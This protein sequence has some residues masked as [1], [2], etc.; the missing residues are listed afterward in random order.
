M[1]Q[2]QVPL[3]TQLSMFDKALVDA[4]VGSRAHPV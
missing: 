3:P 2:N 4:E 1:Y